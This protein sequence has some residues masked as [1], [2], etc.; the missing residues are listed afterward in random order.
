MEG[1]TAGKERTGLQ[2]SEL[3]LV[4]K[5]VMGDSEVNETNN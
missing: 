3:E 2:E 4:L 5:Q 1:T